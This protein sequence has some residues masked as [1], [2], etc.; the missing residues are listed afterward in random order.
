MN[1]N[2]TF[3][4]AIS[5]LKS[6]DIYGSVLGLDNMRAL[7]K[8]LDNPEDGLKFIHVTGTNGKGSVSAF[9]SSILIEAGYKVGSYNSPA[10]LS[11][12]DQYRINME[13]IDNELFAEAMSLVKA[14]CD[15]I[16]SAGGAQPTRF[17]VETMVAFVAFYIEKCDIVV[18]ETGLGG[19]DDATNIVN[20]TLVHVFTSISM[21]HSAVLG[22]TL[23]EIA[24]NKAG[25]IKSSAPVIVWEDSLSEFN[26]S[27]RNEACSVLEKR[28]SEYD[29]DLYRVTKEDIPDYKLKMKGAYQPAN[30]AVA[31][32]A[33][34]VL[35][36]LG[37]NISEDNIKKGL[38]RAEIPFR[39]Q[40]IKKGKVDIILDGAHNPDGAAKFV[41]SLKLNYPDRE[42]I[43]I[44]G[45]FKDKDYERI[46]EITANE[47]SK[48]YIIQ[49]EKSARALDKETLFKTFKEK[50]SSDDNGNTDRI[51]ISNS[52]DEA[53]NSAYHDAKNTISANATH[54]VICCFG[55]LSWL[56]DARKVIDDLVSVKLETKSG[57]I[58]AD[59][60]IITLENNTED[61]IYNKIDTRTE[62]EMN[63]KFDRN[64]IIEG[65]KMILEGVGENPDREGLLDT[66]ERVARMYEEIFSGLN[67]TAKD[68]LSKT[69]TSNSKE[70][71]IEKDITFYSMCEH[72]LLPFFGKAHIAYIPDGKVVGI[73][74]LARCV[75]IYAK[76]PQIQERLTEEI[77]DAIMAY[78][79]PK[80]VLVML[81]AEHT[82]MTMRGVKKP[83]TKT[84]TLATKGKMDKKENKELFFELIRA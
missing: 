62:E 57:K 73:S 35:S 13:I 81:E 3:E 69:F 68:V 78:L 52:I 70:M 6:L 67:E 36:D 72:H 8:E 60:D 59:S 63:E 5:Y 26:D 34:T 53:V 1:E 33:V 29:C 16:V 28:C 46:A 27:D 64:K 37:Y 80:G 22:N 2:M 9:I 41:D 48:I 38:K 18:L 25:I 45:I 32:K 12:T 20:N 56:N 40:I 15:R 11:D 17:E 75:E 4:E 10:V 61:K 54:P 76:K 43:F 83:G 7:A 55:S 47:A 39:F 30:A 19:R 31:L 49:N 71:V 65:V 23:G 84:V 24:S 74:K 42:Y 21:D 50:L 66:P 79:K 14:A 77:A 82:C 44:T 51:V 58:S